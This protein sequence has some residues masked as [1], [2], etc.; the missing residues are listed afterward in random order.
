MT[1]LLGPD[2]RQNADHT[3]VA[4]GQWPQLGM[5][6]SDGSENRRSQ[7]TS[8]RELRSAA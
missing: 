2:G 3:T 4:C 8:F 5:I 6:M 7:W 1:F